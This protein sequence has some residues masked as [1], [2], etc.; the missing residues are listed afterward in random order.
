MRARTSV[1]HDRDGKESGIVTIIHDVTHEREVDRMKT[2]FISTAAHELRT[3]LTSIQGFSELLLMRDDFTEKERKKYLE[4][5]NKQSA[6]LA[7]II[8]DILDVSR[9]ESGK[10]INLDKKVCRLGD[11]IKQ[12]V[13]YFES[14]AQHHTIEL[15]LP[16][17]ALEL[18]CDKDKM[19][20]VFS[21]LLSNAIKFSPEGGA[22]KVKA[23]VIGDQ[24]HFSIQDEG[25]GITPEEVEKIFDK[26]YRIDAS[27]TAIGGTGLGTTIVKQIV[28]AHGGEV[29]VESELGKGTTVRFTIPT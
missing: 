15:E 27:D 7:V 4:Y 22:I 3:P 24:Y 20:Q 23:E 2:E 13:S 17:K 28:E 26:F 19:S 25:T 10:S 29:W 1:I 9:I 11:D 6:G 18:L 14:T 21:N 8:N 12:I 16:E 5:I